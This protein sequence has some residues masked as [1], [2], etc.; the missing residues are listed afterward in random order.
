MTN[1]NLTDH[2]RIVEIHT[3]VEYIRKAQQDQCKLI[4]A[5]TSRINDLESW[6]DKIHGALGLL[7]SG[8][9]LTWAKIMRII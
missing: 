2:D 9:A 1:G 3:H 5:N 8:V 6:K 4:A 7:M